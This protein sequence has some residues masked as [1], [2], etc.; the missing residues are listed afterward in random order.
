MTV[1]ETTLH[2]THDNIRY[3]VGERIECSEEQAK[4]LIAAGAAK[5]AAQAE[6][7]APEVKVEEPVES[8]APETK[9]PEVKDAGAAKKA[10]QAK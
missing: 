8:K 9:A 1:V 2:I 6:T 7:P 10:A 5:K 4:A 3:A